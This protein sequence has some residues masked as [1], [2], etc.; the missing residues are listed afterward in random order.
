[1]PSASYPYAYGYVRSLE[2]SLMTS[3]KLRRVTDGTS[4]ED[5]LRALMDMGYGRGAEVTNVHD[6]E[7]LIEQE[8]K[9]T[10]EAV[11]RMTP[12][13]NITNLFFLKY[14]YQ[15]LKVILKNRILGKE[16]DS[17]LV[18]YG[19]IPV[20]TIKNAVFNNETSYLPNEMKQVVV[21]ARGSEDAVSI[22]YEADKALYTQISRELVNIDDKNIVKY[23]ETQADYFNVI[24]VFRARA[25]NDAS[26]IEKSYLPLG[27]VRL[28]N[29]LAAFDKTDEEAARFLGTPNLDTGIL[30]GLKYFAANK[31]L[32][33]LEKNKDNFFIKLLKPLSYNQFSIAPVMGYLLAKAQEANIIRL[34]MVAKINN[35]P[36]KLIEERLRDLYE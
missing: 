25:L 3:E 13:A 14:D 20:K 16:D 30:E 17:L 2:T 35:L 31:T 26:L 28:K 11:H 34:M 6:Y 36:E 27:N 1:M 8:L 21:N 12:Q 22:G 33:V 10:F 18:D 19:T 24:T 15:N 23:W 29:M 5:M 4:A 32:S 7:L 9:K